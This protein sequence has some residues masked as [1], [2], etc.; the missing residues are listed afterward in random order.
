MKNLLIIAYHF[1][2]IAASGTIRTV[3]YAKYLPHFGWNPII[4]TVHKK[5]NEIEFSDTASQRELP[6][7]I[8]VY[9]SS[10]VEP[11]DVYRFL[12]G[13][14]K[15]FSRKSS[16]LHVDNESQKLTER[17]KNLISS[18]FIPDGKVGWLPGA[19]KE[20]KRV[21]VKHRI[22]AIYST[23]PV[24]TSHLIAKHLA[25]K[26]KRPWI[27]D[28]RDPWPAHYQKRLSPFKQLDQAIEKSVLKHATKIT[29]AWPGI[30]DDIKAR[31]RDF[32]CNKASL[33]TNGFDEDDF[34]NL[35][36]RKFSHFTICYAGTFYRD[37]N[38]ESLLKAMDLLFK[39]KPHLRSKIRL[40]FIG[41]T[42]PILDVLVKKYRL[43]RVVTHI[44]Y[45]SRKKCLEY[46]LGSNLLYLNTLRNCVPGKLF[47][48][49]GLRK[50]ILAL[51]SR[52]STVSEIIQDTGT[53]VVIDPHNISA[54][55][56]Y[57]DNFYHKWSQRNFHKSPKY[58]Q[59]ILRYSKKELT[60]RLSLILNHI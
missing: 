36:A 34:K 29:V 31:H 5:P 17:I 18:G 45:I 54:V 25:R 30:L 56:D 16:I 42:D 47:E 14:K 3:K 53:G 11:Y 24:N 55:R 6:L 48:Y 35:T 7:G 50:P 52:D 44:D 28:F 37:R 19:V 46:L 39:E 9:R 43:D 32:D 59:G 4:L 40:F 58:N 20:A 27:A 60:Y 33:L 8:R 1:P 12:G 26:Y 10:I 13:K 15:Q 49:L 22:D 41:I 51:V 23:S 57:I 38:P 21:F 2:P